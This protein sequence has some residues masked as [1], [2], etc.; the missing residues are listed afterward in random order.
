[1]ASTG[2]RRLTQKLFV[3]ELPLSAGRIE[4]REYFAQ[5]GRVFRSEVIFSKTTG[6]SKRYGFIAVDQNGYENLRKQ[7]THRIDGQRIVVQPQNE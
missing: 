5:F 4:L 3:G 7:N 2:A 1:M 6:I